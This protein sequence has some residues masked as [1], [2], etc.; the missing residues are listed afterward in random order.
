MRLAHI[1]VPR[2]GKGE[3]QAGV[4]RPRL[5]SFGTAVTATTGITSSARKI[6]SSQVPD[7]SAALWR[8]TMGWALR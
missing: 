3:G 5:R 1:S 8:L 4:G 6:T 2:S 7:E